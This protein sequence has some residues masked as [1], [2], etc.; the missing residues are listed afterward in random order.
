M[1]GTFTSEKTE[2]QRTSRYL[3]KDCERRF[4]EQ[5]RFS[6]CHACLL[7]TSSLYVIEP[8][9]KHPQVHL[10]ILDNHID[11][12]A[13]ADDSVITTLFKTDKLGSYQQLGMLERSSTICSRVTIS[14][15]LSCR[16][17]NRTIDSL[18]TIV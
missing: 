7:L 12:P 13:P 5:K 1:D 2:T 4:A 17:V 14:F 15:E 6:S 10:L 9:G 8:I 11:E 3:Q 16:M 18:V